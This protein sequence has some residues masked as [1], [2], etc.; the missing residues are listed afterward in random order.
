MKKQCVVYFLLLF[1]QLLTAQWTEILRIPRTSDNMVIDNLLNIYAISGSE[2]YKYN[3]QGE[4]QFRYSDLKLGTVNSLDVSFPLRPLVMYSD[5]NVAALLD[6]TLSNN[7]GIIQLLDL[8]IGLGTLGCSSVQNHYWFYDA[9]RFALVRFDDRFKETS[10]T[11]NLAQLLNIELKPT[12]LLEFGNR[13]YLNNP[14]TGILVF[15]IFGTFLFRIGLTGINTF[16]VF[17]NHIV[18]FDGEKLVY[19]NM[20]TFESQFHD[21]PKGALNV[22]AYKE[23]IAVQHKDAIVIMQKTSP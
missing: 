9:M 20:T 16:Q 13:C 17:E 22:L 18:Y 10:N 6:N 3:R 21:I 15:D 19:Y 11:G 2:I 14:T 7:R 12:G 5:L 8:G 23:H 4:F 1:P